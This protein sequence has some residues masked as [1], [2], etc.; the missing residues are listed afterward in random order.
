M[1]DS[2]HPYATGY[3]KMAG[4]WF[5]RYD[6]VI[7]AAPANNAPNITNPGT[8]SGA[9]GSSA[10]LQIVASDPDGVTYAAYNLPPGLSINSTGLISGTISASAS[11]GSPYAVEVVVADGKICGSSSVSF[12]WNVSEVNFPPE[13]DQPDDQNDFEGDSVSLQITATDPNG[14][15]LSYSATNLPDGLSINQNGLISGEISYFAANGSPYSVTVTVD[16]G[17]AEPIEASFTWTVNDV[18]TDVPIVTNPGDQRNKVGEII[19]LQIVASD[20]EG[21]EISFVGE[22]LPPNLVI[23][24]ATGEITGEIAEFAT[25]AS[26]YDAAVT[27][28]DESEQSTKI[29]FTW[30]VFTD[31]IYLPLALRK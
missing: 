23:N 17:K 4:E 10:S 20:P 15:D 14:D 25:L 12:T 16:D 13:I 8:K 30:F 2:L 6:E 21:D 29:F 5:T 31:E 7:G 26:P 19:S 9:E 1:I 3:T 11:N 28:T 22:Y 24:L 18:V 27:V